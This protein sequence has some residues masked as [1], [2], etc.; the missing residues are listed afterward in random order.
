MAVQEPSKSI[1]AVENGEEPTTLLLLA[2]PTT[3]TSTNTN[4]STDTNANYPFR[5]DNT[6]DE[7]SLNQ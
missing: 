1:E 7:H 3:T 5:V 2:A 6:H 4:A